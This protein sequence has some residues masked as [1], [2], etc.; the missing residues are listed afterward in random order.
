MA[1]QDRRQDASRKGLE[2]AVERYPS[3]RQDDAI[4]RTGRTEQ[5]AG[6]DRTFDPSVT[7]PTPRQ[8]SGEAPEPKQE[9]FEG[10]QGDPAEGKR[11]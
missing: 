11:R 10:P 7:A 3:V 9:G 2:A 1:D 4:E 8:V 5:V 6:E